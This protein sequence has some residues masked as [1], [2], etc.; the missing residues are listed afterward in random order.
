VSAA[1]TLCIEQRKEVFTTYT[2]V[3]VFAD[4]LG[5][6]AEKRLFKAVYCFMPDHL[7]LVCVSRSDNT[8]LLSAIE[9]FK[10]KTGFWLGSCIPG[11]R[12]QKSF[13]DRVIRSTEELAAA[14][15]YMLD[16]PVRS[17]LV[18]VWEDY[19]FIGAVGL[20]LK[21]FLEEMKPY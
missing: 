4:F 9:E 3:R 21:T 13:H 5:R 1:F 8:D 15:R 14:V 11:I 19:P 17:G 16:N 6:V 7:H 20:D 10:Q 12:W 18:S 2:T